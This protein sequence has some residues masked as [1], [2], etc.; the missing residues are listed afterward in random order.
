MLNSGNVVPGGKA[1]K[2]LPRAFR[3]GKGKT[4]T[5]LAPPDDGGEHQSLKKK[6]KVGPKEPTELEQDEPEV[7]SLKLGKSIEPAEEK[8]REKPGGGTDMVA[9]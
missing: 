4:A 5:A 2:K 7:G 3:G 1:M 6:F 8:K 9:P